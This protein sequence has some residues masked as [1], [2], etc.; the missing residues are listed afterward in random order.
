MLKV[1]VKSLSHVQLSVTPWTV[2]YQSPPS[3]VFSRQEYWTGLPFPSPATVEVPQTSVQWLTP[4]TSYP[5]Q[6]MSYSF[7]RW[8][9]GAT[10]RNSTVS[11][12][13]HLQTGPQWSDQHHLDCFK[14]SYSSVPESVCF[15]FS[16]SVLGIVAA[17]VMGT[18]W[19]SCS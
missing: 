18:I 14:Y 2:A 8:R 4:P 17:Y 7:Y 16:R 19:S 13:S 12:D 15:H 9:E 1:K 6:L 11:S 10:C 3:M 5:R